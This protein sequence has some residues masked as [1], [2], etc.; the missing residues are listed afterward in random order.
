MIGFE[1][2][3]SLIASTGEAHVSLFMPMH[4]SGQDVRQNP[5]RMKNAIKAAE[6]KLKEHDISPDGLL[7]ELHT[8]LA[9]HDLADGFWQHQDHGLAVFVEPGRTH[10]FKVPIDL[11]EVVHVGRTY[12]VKPLLPLL[13]R[14]GTFYVLASSQDRTQLF[15]ASRYAMEPISDDRIPESIE[16]LL[17][18]TDYEDQDALRTAGPTGPVAAT[19][20]N[21]AA[22]SA[23]QGPSAK[24]YKTTELKQ[25]AVQIGNGVDAVL[26]GKGHPLVLAADDKLLGMLR[27][28]ISY[29]NML[30]AGVRDQPWS[31][32]TE[33]DLHAK[34]YEIARPKLE[35]DRN[36]AMERVTA[37]LNDGGEGASD[38]IETVVAA[39]AFGRVEALIVD[40]KAEV[41]GGFDENS[42][43]VR[44]ASLGDPTA[45]D[46]IDLAVVKTLGNGGQVYSYPLAMEKPPAKVAAILRY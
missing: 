20:G 19:G 11:K 37:R 41:W 15:E 38:D 35:E 24:D 46:L 40:Q 12:H 18:M 21:P 34:V 8:K 5:I 2:L 39:A 28:E 16:K 17:G 1:D 30:E 22:V 33:A 6:A 44:F 36:A 14:D 9:D 29:V 25:Y 13:M 4:K 31:G 26:G 10:W 45:V 32:H 23:S 27:D 3:R 43:K 42:G 7:D